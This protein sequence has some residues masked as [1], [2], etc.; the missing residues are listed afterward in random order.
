[1]LNNTVKTTVEIQTDLLKLAKLRAIQEEKTL[2][3]IVNQSL[4]DHLDNDNNSIKSD[5]RKNSNT[6]QKVSDKPKDWF[7]YAG[8]IKPHQDVPTDI[9]QIRDKTMEIK[10]KEWSKQGLE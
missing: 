2:K 7:S 6:S 8:S 9:H 1:M 4:A 3:E 10:A 5:K